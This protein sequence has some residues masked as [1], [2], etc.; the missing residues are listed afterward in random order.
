[1][2]QTNNVYQAIF[3]TN[4]HHY[5]SLWAMWEASSGKMS[6]LERENKWDKINTPILYCR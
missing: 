1:M 3:N 2:L 5:V 6:H 4:T